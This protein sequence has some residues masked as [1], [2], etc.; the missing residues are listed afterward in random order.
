MDLRSL[1]K[2]ELHVHLEGSV[3]PETLREIDPTRTLEEIHARY[4][5]VD[6]MGFLLAYKWVNLHLLEPAHYG[7]ITRRLIESLA[8]Q[9][10]VYAE[11]IVSVGVMLWRQQEFAP[12][13]D[14]IAT[15]AERGAIRVR[16]SFDAVRHLGVELAER[17]AEAAVACRG[18]GVIGFGLGGDERNGPIQDFRHI[19]AYAKQNGL[20]LTP[21]AGEVVGPESV[22]AALEC[23]AERIG[24]GIRSIDDPLLVKH[25]RDRQI[26]LEVSISSNVCTGAVESLASHPVRRLYDAGVPVVL[27]T[28]DPPMFHTTLLREYEIVRDVFGFSEEEVRHTAAQSLRFAFDWPDAALSAGVPLGG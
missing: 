15:E 18:R 7:L 26:P 27:N 12:I 1:S 9:G 19:C 13:F 14:A 28:D 8:A 22:W 20:H 3:Q 4:Q 11:I 5:Y 16:F 23:G 21:H 25:L 6:F 2:A 17:V 10:V 24:H